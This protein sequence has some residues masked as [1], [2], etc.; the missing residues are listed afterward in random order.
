MRRALILG[1][2]AAV[3]VVAAVVQGSWTNRWGVSTALEDAVGRLE[4]IPLDV[5]GWRGQPFEVDPEQMASAH[6]AGYAARRYESPSRM[7]SVTAVVL[8]GRTGPLA[9]HTPDICYQGAG[10]EAEGPPG[11]FSFRPSGADDEAEFRVMTFRKEG[12]QLGQ[13]RLFWTWS[14]GDHWLAPTNPRWTFAR[15]PILYKL[16][17]LREKRSDDRGPL[18]DDVCVKFLRLFLP[19]LDRA[20]KTP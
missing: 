12:E 13:L 7:Q 14:G 16:Y 20:L 5:G 9:V 1:A 4:R 15:H 17:V 18:T 8:C 2:G 11:R 6:V 3:L 10:Y 19:E